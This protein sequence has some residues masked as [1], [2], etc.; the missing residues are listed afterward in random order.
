MVPLLLLIFMV[1][2]ACALKV[3]IFD[4]G[5]VMV[6]DYITRAASPDHYLTYQLDYYTDSLDTVQIGFLPKTSITPTT[7]VFYINPYGHVVIDWDDNQERYLSITLGKVS[8]VEYA[9]SKL[10]EF[11]KMRNYLIS[12]QLPDD[13]SVKSTIYWISKSKWEYNRIFSYS[14][15]DCMELCVSDRVF[16]LRDYEL[17][18]A[19]DPPKNI[20]Y[21][22]HNID[23]PFILTLYNDG[24]TERIISRPMLD[25]RVYLEF[26]RTSIG[27]L[28]YCANFAYH[29]PGFMEMYWITYAP[30][31][32]S[33]GHIASHGATKDTR[34][35]IRGKLSRRLK[36]KYAG[37]VLVDVLVLMFVF[38]IFFIL[39]SLLTRG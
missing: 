16:H 1:T 38:I 37:A 11:R 4:L 10:L 20:F 26:F 5:A 22:T 18:L 9:P 33:D 21:L 6:R 23:M 14:E 24:H 29:A 27:G 8:L 32:L 3:S 19:F 39:A 12:R 15:L 7:K 17:Y 13:L 35:S 34:I 2:Q 28:L 31:I 30:P 36:R 25:P